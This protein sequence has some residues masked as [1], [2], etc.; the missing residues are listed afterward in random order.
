VNFVDVIGDVSPV[1]SVE[2]VREFVLSILDKLHLDNWDMSVVFTDDAEIQRLNK[3]WRGKDEA[4]DVLSFPNGDEYG[5]DDAKR[6]N[7]GDIVIS[8]DT[9]HTNAAYFNVNEETELRRLLVHG[10]LHL[11][12]H[13]HATNEPGEAMLVLQEELLG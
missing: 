1:L 6:Y 10:I 13:D 8:V 2:L 4:T 12:G 11:A 9:L 5:D 3:E 7:A